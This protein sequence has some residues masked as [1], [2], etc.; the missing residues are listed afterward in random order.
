MRRDFKR[1]TAFALFPKL[2]LSIRNFLEAGPRPTRDPEGVAALVIVDV[3]LPPPLDL[4]FFA[5]G[6]L[7][8]SGAV[9]WRLKGTRH[10]LLGIVVSEVV[11]VPAPARL[12]C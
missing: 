6:S 2:S 12:K 3:E 11:G 7:G 8:V 1:K 9:D 4:H 10:A 5:V